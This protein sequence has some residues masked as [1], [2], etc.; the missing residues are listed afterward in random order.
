MNSGEEHWNIVIIECNSLSSMW[1]KLSGYLGLSFVVIDRIKK[2]KD[3]DST[4]CWNEALKQW[5]L[6][7]YN[8]SMFGQPSWRSLLKCVRLVDQRLCKELA[9]RH[10]IQGIHAYH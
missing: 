7:N 10:Q 1:E 9:A 8:T 6:Q 4:A 3:G 2:D 5:I